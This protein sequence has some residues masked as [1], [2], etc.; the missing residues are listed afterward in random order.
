VV[1]AFGLALFL[2]GGTIRTALPVALLVGTVLSL[3]NQSYIIVRGQA[4]IATWLSVAL[5][6]CVPF[7]VSSYGF[8][9]AHRKREPPRP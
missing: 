9:S 7:L 4:T 3:I 6:Y 2:R 8:L 5:D 1:D